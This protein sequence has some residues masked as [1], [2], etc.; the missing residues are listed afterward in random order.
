MILAGILNLGVLLACDAG[1]E[2]PAQERNGTPGRGSVA[3]IHVFDDATMTVPNNWSYEISKKATSYYLTLASEPFRSGNLCDRGGPLDL[4]GKDDFVLW[5]FISEQPFGP[6][7]VSRQR[8]GKLIFDNE[9]FAAYETTGCRPTYRMIFR[10][11]ESDVSAQI[12]LGKEASSLR[13][14]ILAALNSLVAS[15]DA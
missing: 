2:E 15:D 12:A 11:G 13:R 5:A 10:L 4:L 6:G 14:D 8:L 7:N 1:T 9:T 3:D